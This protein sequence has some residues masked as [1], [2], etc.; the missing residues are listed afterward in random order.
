M[1][2]VG[3]VCP[4]ASAQGKRIAAGLERNSPLIREVIVRRVRAFPQGLARGQ[5]AVQCVRPDFVRPNFSSN[6]LCDWH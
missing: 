2:G 1:I 4:I 6:L 3:H 5:T